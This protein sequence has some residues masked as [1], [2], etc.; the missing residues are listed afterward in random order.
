[1]KTRLVV[2]EGKVVELKEGEF[3]SKPSG[4]QVFS[5]GGKSGFK[6]KTE[7]ANKTWLENGKIVKDKKG[8]KIPK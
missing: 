7:S 6:W 4:P 8:K 2:R 3:I 1:M 5:I